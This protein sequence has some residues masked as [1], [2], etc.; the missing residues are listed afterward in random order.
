MK[1]NL[2]LVSSVSNETLTGVNPQSDEFVWLTLLNGIIYALG[3]L[4]N[5]ICIVVFFNPR[6]N[7]SAYKF[8]LANSC[9]EFIYTMIS[10]LQLF[11]YCGSS[12]ASNKQSTP[13]KIYNLWFEK[14]L[15]NCL[16]IFSAMILIYVSLKQYI[17]MSSTKKSHFK[18]PSSLV[19]VL[20]TL[21]SLVFYLPVVFMHKLNDA[22]VSNEATI[23]LLP[24][25]FGQRDEAKLVSTI[26]LG[27][28]MLIVTVVLLSIVIV[29]SFSFRT[30]LKRNASVISKSIINEQQHS[31][32]T[33]R[34]MAPK[35]RGFNVSL[36]LM[37]IFIS[38]LYVVCSTP[39]AIQYVISFFVNISPNYTAFSQIMLTIMHSAGIFIFYFSNVHFKDILD[40]SIRR[41]VC[42][43]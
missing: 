9:S 41:V 22:I 24:T 15:S 36:N 4:F 29:L 30:H 20:L 31:K 8:M 42:F 17:F 7:D 27:I 1:I 14:Y 3:A 18:I 28:E 32:V 5:F 10:I 39:S 37:I 40:S 25:S 12:C 21:A 34:S 2:N 13:A 11:I 23:S 35:K 19:I 16:T 26:L 38:T 6:L 33:R 43:F